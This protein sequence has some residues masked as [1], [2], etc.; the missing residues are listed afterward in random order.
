MSFSLKMIFAAFLFGFYKIVQS[1]VQNVSTMP[2]GTT[3]GVY[4]DPENV[5]FLFD[6][7]IISVPHYALNVTPIFQR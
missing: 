4:P 1:Q 2:I 7:D 3:S 5:P 6:T